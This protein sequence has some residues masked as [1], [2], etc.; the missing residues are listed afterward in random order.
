MTTEPEVYA[1][2]E[3]QFREIHS[4]LMTAA[5][6]CT[7]HAPS[8]RDQMLKASFVMDDII[9]ADEFAKLKPFSTYPEDREKL[10]SLAAKVADSDDASAIELADLVTAILTDEA[11]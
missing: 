9:D 8:V 2:N 6:A 4:A 1:I 10:L 11:L 5:G 7:V 3:D